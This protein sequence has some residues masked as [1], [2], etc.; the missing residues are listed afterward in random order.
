MALILAAQRIVTR[1]VGLGLL[2][3]DQSLWRIDRRDLCAL[4]VDQTVQEVE[5]VGLGRDARVECDLNGTQ[6]RLLVV[7]QHQRQDLHHLPVAARVLEQVALQSPECLGQIDE[8]RSVAQGAG[9]ALD[10]ARMAVRRMPA[11]YRTTVIV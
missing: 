7:M 10:A 11:G 5:D 9:L 2:A 8:R 6:H 3:Q 1:H 4:A